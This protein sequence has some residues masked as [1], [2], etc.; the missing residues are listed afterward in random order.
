[1]N[2]KDLKDIA[3]VLTAATAMI[4]AAL[5]LFR[6]MVKLWNYI[7]WPFARVLVFLG[8]LA[9]PLGFIM[10][11][12]IDLAAANSSRL[13]EQVVI[14]SL[15]GQATVVVFLYALLWGVLLCPKIRFLLKWSA[16]QRTDNDK[17][18]EGESK[19]DSQESGGQDAD[20]ESG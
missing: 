18:E 7:L 11:Y 6:N 8:T 3:A 15:V 16:R 5:A 17:K 19:P 4:A 1:M 9:I 20:C 13:D 14:V 12:F 2:E 10:W